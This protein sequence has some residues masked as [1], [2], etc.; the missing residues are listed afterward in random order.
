MIAIGVILN[1]KGGPV[2]WGKLRLPGVLQRFGICYLVVASTVLMCSTSDFVNNRKAVCYI[3]RNDKKNPCINIKHFCLPFFI[4]CSKLCFTGEK[5]Y[6]ND[7]R[8]CLYMERVDCLSCSS[9]SAHM[10]HFSTSCTR[11]PHVCFS[12]LH[13]RNLIY[14]KVHNM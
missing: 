11:M 2:E 10:S 8:C 5:I 12:T 7:S 14:S 13:F 9:C 4:Q 1:T 3:P 6:C